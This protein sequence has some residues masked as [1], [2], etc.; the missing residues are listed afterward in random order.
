MYYHQIATSLPNPVFHQVILFPGVILSI[1]R[2]LLQENGPS[3]L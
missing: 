1:I 3:N 2:V